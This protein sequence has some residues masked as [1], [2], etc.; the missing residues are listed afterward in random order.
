[1]RLLLVEDDPDIS[2]F[3]ICN[4]ARESFA[5]DHADCGEKGSFLAK[6]NDY[7][8]IIL[9]NMLPGKEGSQIVRE[10]RSIGRTAPIILLS[11]RSEIKIKIDLL[12]NGVDDYVTK[13]FSFAELLARINAILR[14]PR[15]MEGD[16]LRVDNLT[17]DSK[18]QIVSR[19]KKIIYLTRKEFTLLEYMAKNKSYVISRGM[20][21]EHVWDINSDPFSNTIESHILNL[22]KKID[23]GRHKKLIHTVPGRGYKLD[24]I[25]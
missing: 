22:R 16:I 15:S 17:I 20:I 25:N 6:T 23:S 24:I 13:P 5:V 18:R 10:M 7:D 14:R 3:L 9:D 1:M 8:L 4:L 12:N 19:G 11:S 2:D 21:M